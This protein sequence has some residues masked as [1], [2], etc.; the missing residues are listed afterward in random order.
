MNTKQ[1]ADQLSAMIAQHRLTQA[2]GRY[3][4]LKAI[5][6]MLP[7][8]NAPTFEHLCEYVETLANDWTGNKIVIAG[9]PLVYKLLK[10]ELYEKVGSPAFHH[11]RIRVVK[12]HLILQDDR[13]L[14][15]LLERHD[16]NSLGYVDQ[17]PIL[18]LNYHPITNYM[19]SNCEVR[20]MFEHIDIE[21]FKIEQDK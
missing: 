6:D 8:S 13:N 20:P 11:G 2:C 10:H 9:N 4:S 14:Y 17:I 16:E 5:F 15:V 18:K 1:T 21:P 12:E 3:H 19:I 7:L